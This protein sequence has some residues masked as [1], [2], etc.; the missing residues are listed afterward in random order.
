[1][2]LN[3]VSKMFG[4]AATEPSRAYYNRELVWGEPD[5]LSY[6]PPP[7]TGYLVGWYDAAD[8]TTVTTTTTNLQSFTNKAA[9][10]YGNMT[11]IV[12]SYSPPQYGV[13]QY[14]INNL[15]TIMFTGDDGN[16][17]FK[18][19][20]HKINDSTTATFEYDATW[21]YNT[22]GHTFTNAGPF[23]KHPLSSNNPVYL[24]IVRYNGTDWACIRTHECASSPFPGTDSSTWIDATAY[25]AGRPTSKRPGVGNWSRTHPYGN[26]SGNKNSLMYYATDTAGEWVNKQTKRIRTAGNQSPFLNSTH[27]DSMSGH[28][29]MV[30]Y[31]ALEDPDHYRGSPRSFTGSDYIISVSYTHLTLPTNREV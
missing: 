31:K 12:G 15:N 28:T 10:S 11:Q 6:E 17:K 24:T 18:A 29:V 21:Y 16:S 25:L 3:Q 9:G 22:K 5:E 7:E 14:Q 8:N 4:I 23:Q 13:S 20:Q 2:K 26:N 19:G 27:T 1:M 30:V